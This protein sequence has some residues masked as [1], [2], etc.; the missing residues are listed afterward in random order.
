MRDRLIELLKN[1]YCPSPMLCDDKCKYINSKDCYTERIADMLLANGV[2]V[3]PCKIGDTVYE[4]I[5]TKK[6]NYS[7][8]NTSI[9]VGFHIVNAPKKRGHTRQSYIVAYFSITNAIYH[10]SFERIGK[11]VFFTREEAEQALKEG[12][13]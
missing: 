11:T 12:A 13:E 9:C 7:H 5:K 6:G 10:F 1:D 8:I 2:I 3:P 4:V